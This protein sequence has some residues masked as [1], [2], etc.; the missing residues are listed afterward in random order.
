MDKLR[1]DIEIISMPDEFREH[2]DI[3]QP[4]DSYTRFYEN[5]FPQGCNDVVYA[6][7][8]KGRTAAARGRGEHLKG[9]GRDAKPKVGN[10]RKKPVGNID[11]I[12]GPR[13]SP[14]LTGGLN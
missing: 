1:S 12:S 5:H 13:K 14:R 4:L 10:K 9:N 7:F 6:K 11:S 8:V 3:R 2:D